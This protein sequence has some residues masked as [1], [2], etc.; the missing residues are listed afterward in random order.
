MNELLDFI[1]GL[2]GILLLVWVIEGCPIPRRF[3]R[4]SQKGRDD[5]APTG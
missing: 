4:A 1:I 3:K 5:G 2:A